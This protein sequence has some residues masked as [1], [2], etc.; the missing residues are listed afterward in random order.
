M[1]LKIKTGI[2]IVENKRFKNKLK[3]KRFL[4]LLLSK[5]EQEI[6]FKITSKK[7]KLTFI[8]GRWAIKEAIFKALNL[9]ENVLFNNFDIYYLNNAPQF[10]MLNFKNF[11]WN[12]EISITHEKKFSVGFAIAFL[13]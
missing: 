9:K 10:K 8:C 11:S 4:N 2:D 13:K 1:F 7:R 3:N 5:N 6:Y 12:V